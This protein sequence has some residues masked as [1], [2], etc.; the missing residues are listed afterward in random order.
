MGDDTIERVLLTG[1]TGFVGRH[2]YPRLIEEGYEVTCTS[3]HPEAARR[4]HPERAWVYMDVEDAASIDAA[5]ADRDAAYYL[6]HGMGAEGEGAYEAAER[7]AARQFRESAAERGLDR[8]V[9]LGGTVPAGEPSRHLRSRIRTGE[10]LRDG[11]VPCVELRAGM[12]IGPG[13]ESWRIV[14]DLS[15]RLPLMILPNWLK[16]RSEPIAIADVVV[17][18]AHALEIPREAAGAYDLPGPEVMSAQEI[19]LRVAELRD[20]HPVTFEFPLV[21][22]KLSSYWIRLVTR[23][24]P[25]IAR[26]LVHGLTSDLLSR[27]DRSFWQFMPD[28]ERIP[29]DEA[30]RH[31]MRRE[32]FD[33]PLKTRLFEGLMRRI[34]S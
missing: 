7:R 30:A 16:T 5:L 33:L 27:P 15:A 32:R 26:E 8:I 20:M 19:L 3:R 25:H 2:L 34:A 10:I 24:N 11:E 1:A 6:I 12:I 31:T 22:P 14:R 4:R 17:A 23:S 29:F 21:T 9:Y 18:L 28:H 13:S